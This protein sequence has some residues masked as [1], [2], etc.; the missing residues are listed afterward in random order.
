MRLQGSTW[1]VTGAGGFIGSAV[2]QA[3][4]GA[5]VSVRALDGPHDAVLDG[6]QHVQRWRADIT[7]LQALRQVFDG[8]DAVLHLAGPPSVADSMQR[9]CEHARSHV[10]GTVSVLQACRDLGISRLIYLSSA[11]VYA[12]PPGDAPVAETAA[13]SARS[14]YAASKIAAEQFIA[15]AALSQGLCPLTLRPFSIYGPGMSGASLIGGLLRQARQGP[16]LAVQDLRP[17]RDHCHIDDLVR[18]LLH[19]CA[20]DI[21]GPLTLNIGTGV[22]TSVRGVVGTLC[23]VLGRDVCIEEQVAQRRPAGSD[24]PVLVA[25][26]NR[27][28]QCL[29]WRPTLSL[30]DGLQRMLSAQVLEPAA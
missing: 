3:L 21:D 27:A 28:Q 17:V 15:A 14:P 12:R 4:R 2:V 5:G 30:L 9:P 11:E 24:V 16:L 1:A 22:G 18:A 26:I 6:Q 8:A 19:A 25:D 23:A 10:L 20:L 13:L 7:D 29:G